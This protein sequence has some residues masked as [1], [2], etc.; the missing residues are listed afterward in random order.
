M[1][2]LLFAMLLAISTGAPELIESQRLGSQYGL[3]PDGTVLEQVVY[4][5]D[6]ND[7]DAAYRVYRRGEHAVGVND[8]KEKRVWVYQDQRWYTYAEA[9]GK[10]PGGP[11]GLPGGAAL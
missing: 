11:C 3:C 8:T 1:T 7:P 6:P 2:P 10:Y 9:E 5:R 4:D